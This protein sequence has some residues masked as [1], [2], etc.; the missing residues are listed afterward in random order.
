MFGIA[1][2]HVAALL[3]EYGWTEREQVGPAEYVA[4]YLEPA[5]RRMPVS[6]IERFVR[7]EKV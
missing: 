2:Q 5:G 7:A 3:R 6:E 1:P 4:R